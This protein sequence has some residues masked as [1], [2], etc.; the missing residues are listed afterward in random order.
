[1]TCR[2]MRY[3][4]LKTKKFSGAVISPR[5]EKNDLSKESHHFAESG[6]RRQPLAGPTGK[7]G[8][9]PACWVLHPPFMD[10]ETEAD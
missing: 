5:S 6:P 4:L 10:T 7:L 8:N 9:C 3:I 1:M 2:M